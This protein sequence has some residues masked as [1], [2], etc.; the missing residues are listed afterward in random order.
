MAKEKKKKTV[1]DSFK[2]QQYCQFDSFYI[3]EK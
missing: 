1:Q 2:N 3:T